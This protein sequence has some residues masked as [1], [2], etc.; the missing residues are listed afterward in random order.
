MYKMM[1]ISNSLHYNFGCA[2]MGQFWHLSPFS[3]RNLHGSQS[4]VSEN[5]FEYVRNGFDFFFFTYKS[6]N[7]IAQG[8]YKSLVINQ[9]NSRI[10]SKF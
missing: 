3:P 4:T 8:F 5:T 6:S 7:R 10:F 1:F 2:P 9:L